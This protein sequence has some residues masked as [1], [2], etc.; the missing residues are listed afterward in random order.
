MIMVFSPT[1]AF[2]DYLRRQFPMSSIVCVG[3]GAE[4]CAQTLR[5][6]NFSAEAGV[7]P[8]AGSVV[9]ATPPVR[10][11]DVIDRAFSVKPH[12]FLYIGTR[13]M[14]R[15]DARAYAAFF[16]AARFD[17]GSRGESVYVFNLKVRL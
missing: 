7:E 1:D 11:A 17:A 9:L 3:A 14:L 15:H 12:A 2:L 10:L 13:S 6:Y 5:M 4:Q 16:R 8:T